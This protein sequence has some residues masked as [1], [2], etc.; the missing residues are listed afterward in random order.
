MHSRSE[1][2][3]YGVG[4]HIFFFFHRWYSWVNIASRGAIMPLNWES[5][6]RCIENTTENGTALLCRSLVLVFFT[7]I[8]ISLEYCCFFSHVRRIRGRNVVILSRVDMD[9]DN[10]CPETNKHK[11]RTTFTYK[12]NYRRM[13]DGY[14]VIG[15]SLP[16]VY[17]IDTE[18]KSNTQQIN[19]HRALIDINTVFK[20]N[21]N[22]KEHVIEST[23]C[24]RSVITMNM[25]IRVSHPW[26][27]RLANC[28]S[29]WQNI[30]WLCII[31]YYV[32]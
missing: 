29:V 11:H 19:P 8:K 12:Y 24:Q 20:G 3:K 30:W 26:E 22:G 28:N 9:T 7:K 16:S 13:T 18:Q 4:T 32:G 5:K 2:S 6:Q 10:C 27:V 23:Y 21:R 25:S 14:G 31:I 17:N 1:T 15:V